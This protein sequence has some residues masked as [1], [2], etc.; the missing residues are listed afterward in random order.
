[1]APISPTLSR[2]IALATFGALSLVGCSI[3]P[4][5][6]TQEPSARYQDCERAARDYC[7]ES[8]QASGSELDKC[9]AEARFKCVSGSSQ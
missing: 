6:S 9:V 4:V 8:V 5:V 3:A 7:E 2:W 1:M